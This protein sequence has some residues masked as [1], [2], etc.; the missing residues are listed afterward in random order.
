MPL[1]RTEEEVVE[2]KDELSLAAAV[3]S[4]ALVPL[5][6]PAA[7]EAET[8]EGPCVAATASGLKKPKRMPPGSGKPADVQVNV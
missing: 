4:A 2:D 8:P 6:G 1:K 3:Q 5:E 7:L